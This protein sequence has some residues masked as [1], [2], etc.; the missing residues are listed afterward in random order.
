MKIETVIVSLDDVLDFYAKAFQT[1]DGSAIK[2][3]GKTYIDTNA[4]TVIFQLYLDN[5]Q[6][7]RF[8]SHTP[9]LSPLKRKDKR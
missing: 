1:T 7:R 6:E 3:R 5:G 2:H 4:R 9:P 8:R